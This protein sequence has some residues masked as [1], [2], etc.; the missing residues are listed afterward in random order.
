M[1]AISPL[2]ALQR[3]LPRSLRRQ[4]LVALALLAGLVLA[5]GLTAVFAL[6]QT[7]EGSR[8]LAQERLTHLQ[9]AH[10]LA[11]LSLQIEWQA[12]LLAHSDSHAT[13]DAIYGKILGLLSELEVVELHLGSGQN[14]SVLALH[15]AGQRFRNNANV[16]A[17]LKES[18]LQQRETYERSVANRK[19][20]AATLGADALALADIYQHLDHA[21]TAAEVEQLLRQFQ[22][23]AETLPAL[24]ALLRD[25]LDERAPSPP[26]ETDP[27]TL[28]SRLISQLATARRFETALQ[29][30]AE[31]L[32]ASA[33]A[34]SD[35]LTR[36][37]RAAVSDLAASAWR[38]QLWMVALLAAALV[39]AWLLAHYFL[40]RH[41]LARL[42]LVSHYLRRGDEAPES[43]PVQ[44]EDEIAA[45]ARAVEQF[46]ADRRQLA[47]VNAD[48]SEERARQESLFKELADA[49]S[50]LLQSEKMASIGQLAAGVA[51]EINNPVGFVNSNLTTLKGY[52][53]GMLAL[54]AAYEER[55]G[56]IAP[57]TLEK[58]Q[59]LRERLDI[60]YL[61]EDVGPLLEESMDGLGRVRRIVQDLKD[62]SH[63]DQGD[64]QWTNLEQGLDS[65][66]NVVWN[67]IKYKAEVDKHY[68]GVP[69]VECIPSQ[70]NQVFMNLLVNAA[71]AIDARGRIAIRTGYDDETVWVEVQD[72]GKGISPDHL[73]R[74]F[75]PFFTTKPVGKGTGLGLSIS[76]GIVQKHKGNLTVS[77]E[78]GVGTTFRITLPRAAST[79][80]D[81]V[82]QGG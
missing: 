37:Y 12:Y 16:V 15:E 36:D 67:E 7:A 61:K 49:H 40:G 44:G 75:E 58:L 81:A 26:A 51:H 23:A 41:V 47:A 20:I 63:A 46:L 19:R 13:M 35:A 74:V 82:A 30:Q 78:V 17:Q 60:D 6:R 5:G 53:E 33:Q 43:I 77:S 1:A 25:D 65:T 2:A 76:Y 18:A 62:F 54:I 80:V 21:T 34:Q 79:E 70:I 27:F 59:A 56:T 42:H 69:N 71:Q 8:S 24:P 66:L 55:D 29:Q 48:L 64:T 57:E 9:Q 38:N 11:Q 72:T 50:Q 68:A 4:F 31:G 3:R 45:M 28:R 14:E 22:D 73:D 32:R 39:F 52:V 10:D